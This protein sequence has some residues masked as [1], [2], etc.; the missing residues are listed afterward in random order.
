MNQELNMPIEDLN[1]YLELLRRK[2]EFLKKHP[3]L[4]PVQE[5]IDKTLDEVGTN[6]IERCQVIQHIMVQSAYQLSNA[7]TEVVDI[8][9]EANL[10]RVM[11]GLL[12][13]LEGSTK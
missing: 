3:E 13:E 9:N 11:V 12:K 4:L 2:D 10:P 6:P 5:K 7:I 8:I 1:K